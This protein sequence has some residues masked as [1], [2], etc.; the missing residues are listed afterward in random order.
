MQH[1]RCDPAMIMSL[2]AVICQA[3]VCTD[4]AAHATQLVSDQVHSFEY[5]DS[6]DPELVM[7]QITS[8]SQ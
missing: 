6:H 5:P 8:T 1:T 7:Q 3:S 4:G 2:P